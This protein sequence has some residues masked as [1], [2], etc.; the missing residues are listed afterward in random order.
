MKAKTL[1]E[2]HVLYHG[3]LLKVASHSFSL[4]IHPRQETCSDCE[5]GCCTM[6][7]TNTTGQFCHLVTLWSLSSDSMVF[8]IVLCEDAVFVGLFCVSGS[9]Q[10]C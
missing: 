8:F 3:D 9:Q 7:Q 6:P 5:P 1:S 4:H 2:A 10:S